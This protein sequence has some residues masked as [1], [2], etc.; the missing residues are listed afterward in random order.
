MPLIPVQHLIILGQLFPQ[1]LDLHTVGL[2]R[3]NLLI[4]HDV[5]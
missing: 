4:E 2:G 5:D 3:D 1:S